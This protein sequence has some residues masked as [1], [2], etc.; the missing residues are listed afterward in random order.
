MHLAFYILHLTS[1][2][3]YILHL[4][5]AVD[6]TLTSVAQASTAA[7]AAHRAAVRVYCASSRQQDTPTSSHAHARAVEEH[8]RALCALSEAAD[9]AYEWASTARTRAAVLQLCA[10]T[11]NSLHASIS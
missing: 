1:I 7:A 8:S 2:T 3:S 5:G 4:A 11:M 6:D 9:E 10:C